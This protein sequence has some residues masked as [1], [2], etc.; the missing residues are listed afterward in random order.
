[1]LATELRCLPY[2]SLDDT[3]LLLGGA[4]TGGTE[5]DLEMDRQCFRQGRI[6]RS[7]RILINR[8]ELWVD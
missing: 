7:V 5:L 4:A 3:C 6:F 8:V 2:L 1:M